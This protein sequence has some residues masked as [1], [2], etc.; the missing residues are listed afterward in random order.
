MK[1]GDG[2]KN[3]KK[4]CMVAGLFMGA[5]FCFF[6]FQLQSMKPSE[7]TFKPRRAMQPTQRLTILHKKDMVWIKTADNIIIEIPRWYIDQ[8][9]V[10]QLLFLHQKGKNSKNNPIN[11][12]MV[13]SDQLTLLQIALK[14]AIDPIKFELFCN[15]LMPEEKTILVNMSSTLQAQGLLSLVMNVMYPAELGM[16]VSNAGVLEPVLTYLDTRVIPHIVLDNKNHVSYVLFSHKGDFIV[17][18]A[19][20]VRNNL[21][22]W[23][24]ESGIK[25]KDLVGHSLWVPCLDISPHDEYIVSGASSNINNLIVWDYAF[26]GKKYLVGHNAWVSCVAYSPNGKYIVSGS[27]GTKNNLILWNSETKEQIK[28]LEGHPANVLCCAWSP[29]GHYIVSGSQAHENN[30]I[31]W[32]II[33]DEKKVLVGNSGAVHCVHFSHNGDYIISGSSGNRDNLII[34]DGKTGELLH[35]LYGHGQLVLCAD[36]S[37]DDDYIISGSYESEHNLILWNAKTRKIIRVLEGHDTGVNCAQFS[38]DGRL[39]ASGAYGSHNNLIIWDGTTGR[40]IKICQGHDKDVRSISFHPK[41]TSLVSGAFCQR[42]NLILFNIENVRVF[43]FIATQLNIAQARL[44]YRCYWA[45]INNVPVIIEKND[46]E[47]Q[48]YIT[49]PYTVQQLMHTYFSLEILNV[50]EQ[51]VQGKMKEF[52]LHFEKTGATYNEKIKTLKALMHE[53]DKHSVSYK[54]SEQLLIELEQK[55]AFEEI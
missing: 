8:M 51:T 27:T 5:I 31:L 30:L 26:G 4:Y 47:Y 15:N 38:P 18:G 13:T 55:S 22:V 37:P 14:N 12:S 39:I 34:W 46:P 11:A 6:D 53:S 10:L 35:K 45:K 29:D 28:I 21:I 36:F 20:G 40:R 54:A 17:S 44:L 43:D 1:I 50:F 41:G 23:D 24:G 3:I 2:M 42:N 9:K 32:N 19:T 33:T 7:F 25:Q 16:L 52:R 48:I 49:L